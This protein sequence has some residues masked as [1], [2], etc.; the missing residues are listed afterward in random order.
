MDHH[1]PVT[2]RVTV[3]I[4]SRLSVM[5][6]AGLDCLTL[7]LQVT[8]VYRVLSTGMVRVSVKESTEP[9]AV[10]V[11]VMGSEFVV[12]TH[13]TSTTTFTST[14]EFTVME[15]VRVRGV[16]AVR[17]SVSATVN[18]TAGVGTGERDCSYSQLPC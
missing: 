2:L 16:P 13:V 8:P 14:A 18:A 1:S 3:S 5:T 10:E 9:V 15:Q 17:G 4:S 6:A 7:A 11:V 12:T